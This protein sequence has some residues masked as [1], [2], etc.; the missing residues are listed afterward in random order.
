MPSIPYNALVS[1]GAYNLRSLP[2]ADEDAMYDLVRRVYMNALHSTYIYPIVAA[3][4]ALITTLAL[5]N[6]NLKNV[7]MDRKKT[8]EEKR[9]E[10]LVSQEPGQTAEKKAQGSGEV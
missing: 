7:E 5:E 1:A 8:A 3:G 4:A 10:G 2:G 9:E 6:K